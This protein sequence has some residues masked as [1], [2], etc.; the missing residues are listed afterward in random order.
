MKNPISLIA[1]ISFAGVLTAAQAPPVSADAQQ[2]MRVIVEKLPVPGS[3][4][5]LEDVLAFKAD[6]RGSKWALQRLLRDLSL[7]K[8]TMP[9]IRASYNYA[10]CCGNCHCN[11]YAF[12]LVIA[13]RKREITNN[14]KDFSDHELK[15]IRNNDPLIHKYGLRCEPRQ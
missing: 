8:Q 9:E 7:K 11:L 13:R 5:S 1:V 3:S 15:Q 2:V 14:H 6:M 4:S 10:L 12:T